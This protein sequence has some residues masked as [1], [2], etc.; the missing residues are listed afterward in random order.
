MLG[1]YP[2]R[3]TGLGDARGSGN[4]ADHKEFESF[5]CVEMSADAEK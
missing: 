5:G 3:P 2:F 4:E 1:L